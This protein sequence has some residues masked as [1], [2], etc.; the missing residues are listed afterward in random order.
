MN[1]ADLSIELVEGEG[2]A[3]PALLRWLRKAERL[4][5][6]VGTHLE[7]DEKALPSVTKAVPRLLYP[8]ILLQE[9]EVMSLNRDLGLREPDTR[10]SRIRLRDSGRASNLRV[11]RLKGKRTDMHAVLDDLLS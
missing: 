4:P 7:C 10:P 11:K 6:I 3:R 9:E 8:V 2:E 1:P 5:V